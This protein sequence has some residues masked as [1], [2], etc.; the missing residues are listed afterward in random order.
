MKI[1]N[2]TKEQ[3]EKINK[4]NVNG[5]D[6]ILKFTQNEGRGKS[7]LF[8][9]EEIFGINEKYLS[10]QQKEENALFEHYLK[11]KRNNREKSIRALVLPNV[12]NYSDL[13]LNNLRFNLEN[14]DYKLIEKYCKLYHIHNGTG[15]IIKLELFYNWIKEEK[16][17]NK[18]DFLKIE[19]Y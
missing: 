11:L 1:N 18:I 5:Y 6:V 9:D 15:E 10:N 2:K 16:Q 13:F 7:N 3:L 19:K 14:K 8:L 4:A 17:L 12:Y